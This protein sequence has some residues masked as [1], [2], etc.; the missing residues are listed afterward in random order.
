[1]KTSY[2]VVIADDYEKERLKFKKIFL[3]DPYFTIIGEAKN[4]MEAI[5]LC[6]EL[7]PDLVLLDM[8]MPFMGGLDAVKIIKEKH[9]LM[10]VVMLTK[11]CYVED[12]F[13]AVQYGAQGFLLKNMED[14][15]LLEYLRGLVEGSNLPAR[16]IAGKI[17]SQM[18]VRHF[19]EEKPLPSL[20]SKEREIL[21]LVTK[22]LTNKQISE[23]LSIAENTVKNHIKNLL[24]K[25][26]MENRV[27][28]AVYSLK[29]FFD[30]K[31]N[32]DE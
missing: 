16:K 25:L 21:L 2:R 4:G 13:A 8:E 22:G 29:N 12:F 15:D 14:E 7:L 30:E 31:K 3:K 23:Q 19:H 32:I 17:W 24:R 11:A 26:Q 27:Q 5:K 1:M 20:T 10:K 18:Q 9:P 6:N 28:L